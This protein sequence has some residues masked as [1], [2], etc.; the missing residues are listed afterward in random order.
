MIYCV[1]M[2]LAVTLTVNLSHW[3]GFLTWLTGEAG[4]DWA[5]TVGSIASILASGLFVGMQIRGT[6]EIEAERREIENQDL[7]IAAKKT[8]LYASETLSALIFATQKRF[9]PTPPTKFQIK[10]ISAQIIGIHTLIKDIDISKLDND[11]LGHVF[12]ANLTCELLNNYLEAISELDI[13]PAGEFIEMLSKRR[14]RVE[15]LVN[16]IKSSL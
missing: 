14:D 6:R 2:P 7:C 15:K 9:N 13:Y 1:T 5:Q 10:G 11:I 4:A 16:F 8:L 12:D 3:G